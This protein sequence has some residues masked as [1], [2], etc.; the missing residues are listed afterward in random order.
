MTEEYS[1]WLLVSDIDGTLNNKIRRLPKINKQKIREYVDNGGYFTLCSGRNL[2]S[3][4]PHYKKLSIDQSAKYPPRD[5][6]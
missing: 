4:T 6:S 3:L 2:Q 5:G 1:K